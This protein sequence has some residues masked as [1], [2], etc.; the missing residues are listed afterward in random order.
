MEHS[1]ANEKWAETV[2][3]KEGVASTLDPSPSSPREGHVIVYASL[4]GMV[5]FFSNGAIHG[6]NHHF[7]LMLLG[8][9]QEELVGQVREGEREREREG[10]K[11][12][13]REGRREE[14]RENRYMFLVCSW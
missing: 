10:G 8:Y 5:S 7:M 4:S 6:C 2:K 11:E 1:D 9:S 12:R 14:M 13:E 3:D